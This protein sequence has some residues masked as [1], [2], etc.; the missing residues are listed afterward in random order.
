MS[1]TLDCHK[2]GASLSRHVVRCG[3]CG[4]R[5]S[6]ETLREMSAS[7]V[8]DMTAEFGAIGEP[9]WM[10]AFT[11]LSPALALIVVYLFFKTRVST[12]GAIF[13]AAVA[14]LGV[15]AA[16][17]LG[18]NVPNARK[19][20]SRYFTAT[21]LPQVHRFLTEHQIQPSEFIENARFLLKEEHPSDSDLFR[22]LRQ[23]LLGVS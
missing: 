7:F 15:F 20:Q 9:G 14:A 5:L 1:A 16:L 18:L 21:L 6:P 10:V 4:S 12:I 8:R 19:R 3:Y 23:H 22:L 17:I 13:L 11:F 2:C